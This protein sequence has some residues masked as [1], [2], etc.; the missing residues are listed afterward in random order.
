M[1]SSAV[2]SPP[3][4]ILLLL[5]PRTGIVPSSFHGESFASTPSALAIGTR[6]E[7]DGTTEVNIGHKGDL[8]SDP[9]LQLRW[10][11]MLATT[12]LLAV[13]T[14]VNETVLVVPAGEEVDIQLWTNDLDEPD[15][16]WCVIE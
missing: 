2:L 3:N 8:P 7:F 12:G 1:R 5:D 10:E 13:L 9:T 16:I 6:A 11:G 15:I 4:S 14:C